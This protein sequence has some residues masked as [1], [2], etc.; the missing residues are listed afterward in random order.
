MKGILGLLLGLTLRPR[1][2]QLDG[3][4]VAQDRHATRGLSLGARY[5]AE[6]PAG[7]P[8]WGR[9]FAMTLLFPK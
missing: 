2:A 1:A 9:R 3:T 6:K 5:Q 8:D 4:A 7:G